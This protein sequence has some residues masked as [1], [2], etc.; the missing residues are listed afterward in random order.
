MRN[1]A[2]KIDFF[3]DVVCGWCFVMSPKLRKLAAELPIEVRHRTFV[4]QD[5]PKQMAAAFGSKAKAK[6]TIL[7]HWE[8]CALHVTQDRI[9]VEGMRRQ[10]FDYPTGLPGAKASKAAEL[11]AGYD[12]HW[13]YFDAMQAAH[14]TDNRN[15]ADE[16]VLLDIAQSCGLD[17]GRMR[18]DMN[19]AQ[20]AQQVQADRQLA[21]RWRV[22]AVP[23]LIVQ[24][25][26][27]RL[28]GGSVGQMRAE[29]NGLMGWA[30]SA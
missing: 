27:G 15:V 4:L 7:G 19:G 22:N 3:H 17:V 30:N 2:L 8:Q 13:D 25:G 14:L 23:T 18:R 10:R 11:Q 21:V 24:D 28:Q 9:N 20:I 16:A 1:P 12:G 5:S 6:K 26:K 29:L